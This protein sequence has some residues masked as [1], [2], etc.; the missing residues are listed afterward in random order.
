MDKVTGS[1]NEPAAIKEEGASKPDMRLGKS[2]SP[3]HLEE[4]GGAMYWVNDTR[5]KGYVWFQATLEDGHTRDV[6][7]MGLMTVCE[8]EEFKAHWVSQP[9]DSN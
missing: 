8:W 5:P 9:K 2:D 3:W 7:R 6:S 4:I 1:P